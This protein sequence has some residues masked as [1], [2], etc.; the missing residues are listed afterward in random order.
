MKYFCFDIYIFEDSS[1]LENLPLLNIK[2]TLQGSH[3]KCW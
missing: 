3:P 2:P 1:D